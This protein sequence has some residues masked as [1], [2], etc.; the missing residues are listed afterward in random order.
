MPRAPSKKCIVDLHGARTQQS[1][2]V[3]NGSIRSVQAVIP[4]LQGMPAAQPTSAHV[5]RRFLALCLGRWLQRS[6]LHPPGCRIRPELLVCANRRQKDRERVERLRGVRGRNDAASHNMR[7][8]ESRRVWGF[9]ALDGLPKR[10]CCRR[11]VPDHPVASDKKQWLQHIRTRAVL[12]G[13]RR[14]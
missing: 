7:N 8:Q 5:D 1:Q 6:G 10:L 14:L 12:F 2:A 4:R 9:G 3:G 13:A 11:Q